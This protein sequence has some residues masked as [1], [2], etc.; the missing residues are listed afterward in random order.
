M[1]ASIGAEWVLFLTPSDQRL[2]ALVE[3]IALNHAHL[4]HILR[5]TIKTLKNIT[6]SEARADTRRQNSGKLRPRIEKIARSHLGEGPALDEL[7][8]LLE[9]C[10]KCSTRRNELLHDI[11]VQQL[12]GDA[13]IDTDERGRQPLPTPVELVALAE[14]TQ[15][16]INE[17]NGARLHGPLKKAL[18]ASTS[19]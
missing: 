10:H 15:A 6:P 4:E 19:R 18:D 16:L 8:V 1:G 13:F 2:L 14:E 5:M 12:D 17:F 7:I 9:R 3:R 11:W